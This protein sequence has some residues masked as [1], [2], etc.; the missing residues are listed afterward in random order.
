MIE[1]SADIYNRVKLFI[2]KNE[3]LNN[4][5]KILLSLSAGKDSMALLDITLRLCEEMELI[6]AI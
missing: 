4:G 1:N 6:A 2:K 5:V 3:L